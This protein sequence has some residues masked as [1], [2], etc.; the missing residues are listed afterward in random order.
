MLT[1]AMQVAMGTGPLETMLRRKLDLM[2]AAIVDVGE[3]TFFDQELEPFYIGGRFS[4]LENQ[5][6]IGT[7]DLE[8]GKRCF[9]VVFVQL[10]KVVFKTLT[11]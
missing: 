5:I 1:A 10:F 2:V 6:E 8:F 4:D 9:F 11:S 3:R 7:N